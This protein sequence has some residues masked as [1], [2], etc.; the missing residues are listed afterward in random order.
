M[1]KKHYIHFFFIFIFSIL[2]VFVVN[3]YLMERLPGWDHFRV[4]A[5][6]VG[7]L[8]ILKEALQQ[9]TF[10][11]ISPHYDF[12]HIFYADPGHYISPLFPI[13]WLSII[14]SPLVVWVMRLIFLYTIGGIG[15]YLFVKRY[16][17]SSSYSLAVS[18]FYLFFPAAWTLRYGTALDSWVYFLPLFLELIIRVLHQDKTAFKIFVILSFISHTLNLLTYGLINNILIIS[19]FSFFISLLENKNLKFS[20]LFTLKLI[21]TYFL[22]G[23]FFI[24]PL[25]NLTIEITEFKEFLCKN[26]GICSDEYWNLE[27]YLDSLISLATSTMSRKGR[28]I[29]YYTPI[30]LNI[31]GLFTLLLANKWKFPSS[32]IKLIKIFTFMNF[33]FLI[34]PLLIMLTPLNKVFL[35]RYQFLIVPYLWF[36]LSS[37]GLYYAFRTLN[38]LGKGSSNLFFKYLSSKRK[39]N[40]AIVSL[41][42]FC[43]F[44]TI[45]VYFYPSHRF[46]RAALM[47]A[48]ESLI[49]LMYIFALINFKERNLFSYILIS[50]MGLCGAFGQRAHLETFYMGGELGRH[51]DSLKIDA[52]NI[53]KKLKDDFKEYDKEFR[54]FFASIG[55]Q[56][57]GRNWQYIAQTSLQPLEGVESLYTWNYANHPFI[58]ILRGGFD[59]KVRLLTN[60]SPSSESIPNSINLLKLTGVKY[61]VS[62]YTSLD[63]SNNSFK[64][65]TSFP[66]KTSCSNIKGYYTGAPNPEDCGLSGTFYL[67]EINNPLKI[68]FFADAYTIQPRA[69]IYKAIIYQNLPPP[70]NVL[71]EEDPKI[72]DSNYSL[73]EQSFVDVTQNKDSTIELYAQTNKEKILVLSYVYWPFWQATI[74]GV[75]TK[76][77]RAFGGFMAIKVPK[78]AHTIIF[79][80]IPWDFYL[81]LFIS[82]L[83]IFITFFFARQQKPKK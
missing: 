78:G 30:F 32:T 81:G 24:I 49:L 28:D 54:R 67:Y 43:M 12:G 19:L 34:S 26:M 52:Q 16:T 66:N 58:F 7:R 4:D 41:F 33:L 79:K 72:T 13:Y 18:F 82:F 71:L 61:V 8:H 44:V 51:D 48:S 57:R 83:T 3:R 6:F 46:L 42:A 37:I 27:G 31:T 22:V 60:F 64:Y 17:K 59:K 45:F 25:A 53:S 35:V 20:L 62:A 29:S 5:D 70:Q 77:L 50:I 56:N 74:D 76:I 36:L 63:N 14:A 55:W 9:G 11:Y 68:A 2:L 21:T 73:E 10:P 47:I 23:A 65:I 75:K 80:Y 1:E 38:K 69:D 39:I 15:T 40:I